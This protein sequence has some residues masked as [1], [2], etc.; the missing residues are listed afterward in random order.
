[1]HRESPLQ[2]SARGIH[3]EM[4]LHPAMIERPPKGVV[5]ELGGG[6][7]PPAP[8]PV[9]QRLLGVGAEVR[10]PTPAIF[11]PLVYHELLPLQLDIQHIQRHQFAKP[12]PTAQ[13][14]HKDRPLQV[15]IQGGEE[16]LDLCI[17]QR[18]R[19]R[20]RLHQIMMRADGGNLQLFLADEMGI[21]AVHTAQHGVDG[22]G[23]E[24]SC[25]E[26]VEEVLDMDTLYLQQAGW[27]VAIPTV[28]KG[29]Q[30]PTVGFHGDQLTIAALDRF[31]PVNH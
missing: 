13:Q 21:K 3:P 25:L 5:E 14:Q 28:H 29:F 2:S 8:Q 7:R 15:L 11:V 22:A 10:Y 27:S 20:L 17:T 19:E 31:Q 18:A 4:A 23:L 9:S 6:L 30:R 12:N 24:A 1:M 26:V 16:A